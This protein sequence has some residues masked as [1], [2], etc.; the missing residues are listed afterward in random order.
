[1]ILNQFNGTP[2]A[3]EVRELAEDLAQAH[4]WS[5][6]TPQEFEAG[7]HGLGSDTAEGDAVQIP[8][9]VAAFMLAS[10]VEPPTWWFQYLDEVESALERR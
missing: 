4:E 10:A 6:V 9:L 7:I 2:S 3:Q 5:E 1:M 8:F